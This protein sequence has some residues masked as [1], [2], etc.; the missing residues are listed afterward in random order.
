MPTVVHNRYDGLEPGNCNIEVWGRYFAYCYL[1]IYSFLHSYV[2]L[3]FYPDG[4]QE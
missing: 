2:L 1:V 3:I 4:P